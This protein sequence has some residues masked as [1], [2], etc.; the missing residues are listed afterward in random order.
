MTA[1]SAPVADPS[2]GRVWPGLAAQQVGRCGFPS[3]AL[4]YDGLLEQYIVKVP[5]IQD[6]PDDQLRCAAQVSIATD[7][8]IDFRAP[9]NRRYEQVYWPVAEGLGRADARQWLAKHG[10]LSKLP[11]YVP[12]KT[13]D[14][15][16]ARELE[17]LCGPQA[18]GAFAIEQGALTVKAGSAAH[19]RTDARTLDC[20]MNAQW[21]SG[22]PT[23]LADNGYSSPQQ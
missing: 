1:A 12:G 15:T 4:S 17:Q 11:A 20:L 10:L 21:A 16:Y 14:L 8:Y 5:G 9:L 13:D 7:Y 2:L 3:V 22:L 19:P 6:A 18:K 23:S